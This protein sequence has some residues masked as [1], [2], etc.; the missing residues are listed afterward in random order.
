MTVWLSRDWHGTWPVGR[1][2]YPGRSYYSNMA[3]VPD[4]AGP[5]GTVALIYGREGTHATMPA[6]T[7]VARFNRAWLTCPDAASPPP[8]G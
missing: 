8:P 3:L 2:V 7:Y 5:E 6:K 4:G 1:V